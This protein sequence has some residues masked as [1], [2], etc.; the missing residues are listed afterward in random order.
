MKGVYF[1]V[2]GDRR[3]VATD[4]V[5]LGKGIL[6]MTSGGLEPLVWAKDRTM[7]FLADKLIEHLHKMNNSSFT[8]KFAN[9]GKNN[10]FH[11]VR[12]EGVY[13]YQT[14]PMDHLDSQ[15]FLREFYNRIKG[16]Y[17]G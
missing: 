6:H 1:P 11:F 3:N 7:G 13:L 15:A 4:S 2:R 12:N 10:L 5:E 8:V 9:D 16:F 14:Q 17:K